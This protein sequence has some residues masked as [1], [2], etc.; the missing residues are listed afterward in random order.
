MAK[1]KNPAARINPPGGKP[2]PGRVPDPAGRGT[3]WGICLFLAAITLAVFGQTLRHGF[4][5]YDD[6]I[7]VYQDAAVTNGLTLAGAARA[8]TH[9]SF[10][11]W[12]PLTTLSHMLDCQLYGLHPGGHHLTNILLHTA[13]VILLFLVLRKMT[14]SLW[15]SAF[16][17]ALFAIHPLH[18]ESVAW[19]SER[20]DVLSG[21]FFM[22]T[23]WAYV[24]YA[25]NPPR[26]SR[27]LL[28]MLCLALGLM[29]KAMLVTLPLV[30]LLLDY[31]PL[32][33]IGASGFTICE[34]NADGS[35]RALDLRS[36]NVL[37]KIPLL[38]LS[39]GSAIV[40]YSAQANVGTMQSLEAS[41]LSLRMANASVSA[42]TYLRQ[43]F[44]P[45]GLA[46]LYPYPFHGLPGW[47]VL[48]SVLTLAAISV[49]AFCWRRERPYL[50]AGWLWYLVM[51]L[52]VIGLVQS[53]AQA[54]AD[55]YTYLP[56]IGLYIALTWLA[57]G[58]AGGRP[59]GRVVLGWLAGA[60]IMALSMVA[61]VQASYWRNSESLWKHTL[62]CTRNNAVALNNFGSAVFDQ[63][64]TDEALRQFQQA[65]AIQPDYAQAYSNLG[66]AQ[67][68][69]GRVDEAISEMQM[70]VE[71]EPANAVYLGNLGQ[72]LLQKGRLDDA[73]ADFQAS[74]A[75]EP[76]NYDVHNNLGVVLFHEGRF[77]EAIPHILK[78]LQLQPDSV[79][80][81]DN[82]AGIAW[83]LAASPDASVRNGPKA[84]EL[85]LE[86]DRLSGG[87]DPVI[88]CVLAGAFAEDRRFPDAVAE[89]QRAIQLATEQSKPQLAAAVQAQ[90][91]FYL[92]DRPFRD[93]SIHVAASRP[94]Q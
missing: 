65:V 61:F 27:Y 22:L 56:Q 82:L 17:A 66:K 39:L 4:V 62:A 78:A 84:V 16:V 34:M 55:R 58:L 7:F 60:A 38:L 51:L 3:V 70:A 72:A 44:C 88:S 25:Q 12:D 33:R 5:N 8:F 40:A 47:E 92:T 41:P 6:G 80:A 94:G 91:G 11:F 21:F 9:G 83:A 81:R 68:K 36:R 90:L 63:G 15:P 46:V 50:L 71:L 31:W 59:H 54:H 35:G 87:S 74:L 64:R 19:V 26:L 14:G 28:V 89:A 79:S 2:S 32:R 23:L 18:V 37:E 52:P 13:S 57:V 48:L 73:V 93:A 1:Q 53:G 42:A 76:D 24:H 10:G 43:M 69:N 45:T 29:S 67:L 49:A 20:K 77:N 30:L 75:I 86:A 85:A